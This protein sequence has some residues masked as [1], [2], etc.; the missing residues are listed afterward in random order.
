M[1]PRRIAGRYA[2]AIFDLAQQQGKTAEYEGELASLAGVIT[3]MP[4]LVAVLTHPEIP[5][6]QKDT[7]LRRAFEGKVSRDV[8]VLLE[9]LIKRGH[10]PDIA[11]IHELFTARWN[12][13]RRVMPVIVTTPIPLTPPQATTLANV[14]AKRT[15]STIQ[16]HQQVNPEIIAGMV[17][18]MGDRVIDASARTTL[19][20]LRASMVGA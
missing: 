7:V 12:A 11:T 8:L 19:E 2:E 4:D 13:V 16:L 18:T 10:E 1:L 3:A 20:Q 14:L 17:I 6:A 15:G 9:L 5:L